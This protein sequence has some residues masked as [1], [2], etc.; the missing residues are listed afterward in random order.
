MLKVFSDEIGT[1]SNSAKDKFYII[2]NFS[3]KV[4]TM[5]RQFME[6]MSKQEN[7]SCKVLNAIMTVLPKYFEEARMQ[8]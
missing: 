6:A 2:F 1:L 3:D 5:S 4:K 7:E 8:K